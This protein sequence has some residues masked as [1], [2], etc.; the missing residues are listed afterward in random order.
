MSHVGVLFELPGQLDNA[1][2]RW[3]MRRLSGPMAL[4]LK[5]SS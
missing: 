5:S 4:W 3:G 2:R 1:L